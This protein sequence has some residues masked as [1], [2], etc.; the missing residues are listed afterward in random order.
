MYKFYLGKVKVPTPGKLEIKVKSAN[1]VIRLAT[2]GEMNLIRQPGLSEFKFKILLPMIGSE[3]GP[4]FYLKYLEGL[5]SSGKPFQFIINR[6]D[7]YTKEFF[8][9]KLELVGNTA[10]TLE[11]FDVI[12][13]ANNGDDIEVG[14]VLKKY[15]HYGTK[16]VA[17]QILDRP[18]QK[19]GRELIVQTVRP[20]FQPRLEGEGL[21]APNRYVATSVDTKK[22]LE[23]KYKSRAII[24]DSKNASKNQLKNGDAV[25]FENNESVRGKV[26]KAWDFK[27]P[28][29]DDFDTTTRYGLVM[30][31]KHKKLELENI[32]PFAWLEKPKNTW[33]GQALKNKRK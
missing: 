8:S 9:E 24:L 7:G 33:L 26:T 32:K 23:K 22:N 2:D 20:P 19:K 10:V 4:D 3:K 6:T 17:L 1:K 13:D 12:E 5:M 30:V 14:V 28:T 25:I 16:E 15:V 29:I 11:S 18:A 21:K 31:E 27:L